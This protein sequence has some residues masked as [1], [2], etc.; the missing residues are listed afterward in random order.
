MARS[1]AGQK[2]STESC[3]TGCCGCSSTWTK[4]NT[5][6]ISTSQTITLRSSRTLPS[7][8]TAIAV[9]AAPAK[10]TNGQRQAGPRI[11]TAAV[12]ITMISIVAQPMFWAMLS[13]VGRTEPRRPSM[14]RIET[15]AGAPVV[16]P[17]TAEAP[18][19]VAPS[20]QPTMIARMASGTEPVVVATSAPV[21]GP[22]RLIPRLPHIASWSMKAERPGRFGG[23]DQRRFGAAG[24]GLGCLEV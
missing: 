7:G 13:T 23:E 11:A 10:I 22:K 17:K 15:M 12:A 18:S 9:A 16:A 14:P 8:R 1:T 20:A 2:P 6:A 19:S 3:G 5:E 4:R 24:A 21:S